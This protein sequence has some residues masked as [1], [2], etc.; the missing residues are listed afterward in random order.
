VTAWAASQSIFSVILDI[1]LIIDRFMGR[2][3]GE[4]VA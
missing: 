3:S 2:L 4:S 1:F